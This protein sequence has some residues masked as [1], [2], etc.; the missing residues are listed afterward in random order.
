LELFRKSAEGRRDWRSGP[1]SGE[2]GELRGEG[3]PLS[4]LGSAYVGPGQ[5]EKAAAF[6]QQAVR[7]GREIKD[8]GIVQLATSALEKL[9]GAGKT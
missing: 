7:I 8:P 1:G 5:V 9:P 2:R 6:L 3:A 4:N